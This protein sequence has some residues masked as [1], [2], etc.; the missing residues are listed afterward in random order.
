MISTTPPSGR[1]KKGRR[2]RRSKRRE[3][4][5]S[6]VRGGKGERGKGSIRDYFPACREVDPPK[7]KERK[8]KKKGQKCFC[9]MF[10]D[11]YKLEKEKKGG[12]CVDINRLL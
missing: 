10:L 11:G 4:K 8:K 3:L 6:K 7:G 2:K 12:G 5:R 9:L 1:K